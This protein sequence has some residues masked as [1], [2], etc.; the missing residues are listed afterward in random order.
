MEMFLIFPPK[1]V[2]GG[3]TGKFMTCQYR[4][5]TTGQ[6]SEQ[7]NCTKSLYLVFVNKKIFSLHVILSLNDN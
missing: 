2:A 6:R 1:I 7:I 3:K 4:F 5:N